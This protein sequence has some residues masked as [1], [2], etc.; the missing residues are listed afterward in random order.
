MDK[1][2]TEI[3]AKVIEESVKASL[4][5]IGL[6]DSKLYESVEVSIQNDSISV[7]MPEYYK[8]VESGRRAGVK[9]VPHRVL[10]KWLK[11]KKIRSNNYNELAWKI[12]NSIFKKGIKPRPFLN[13]AIDNAF[14]NF[15]AILDIELQ[16][17]EL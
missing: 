7:I 11:E 9:K 10:V 15:D 5:N 12:Q 14:N 4:V 6:K 2:L 1:K 8:Y 17:I 3:F 16:K 13:K